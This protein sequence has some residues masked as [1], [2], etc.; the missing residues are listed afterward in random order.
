M[1]TQKSEMKL[2]PIKLTTEEDNQEPI[3]PELTKYGQV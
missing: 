3:N 1:V 2:G